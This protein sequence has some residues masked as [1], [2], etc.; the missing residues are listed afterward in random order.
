[1]SITLDIRTDPSLLNLRLINA[2]SALARIAAR[3]GIDETILLQ[4]SGIR[5]DDLKNPAAL[6]TIRQELDVVDRFMAF[7]GIPWMGFEVGKDYNFSSNGKLGIAAMCCDTVLDAMKL[8][9]KYIHLTASYLSYHLVVDEHEARAHLQELIPLGRNRQFFCEAG[10]TSLKCKAEAVLVKTPFREL[11]FAYAEPGYSAKYT[12]HFQC[13]VHFNAERHMIVFNPG[14]LSTPLPMAN[15]LLRQSMEQ[16]CLQL[17]ARMQEQTSLA[18]RVYQEL[19]RAEMDFPS[20]EQVA[21]RINVSSR[22]LRRQLEKENTSFKT[23]LATVRRDKALELLQ[24]TSLSIEA[25]ALRLGFSEVP[26]FYRAFKNWTGHPPGH[27]R[28]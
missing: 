4:G 24:T 2:V 10:V 11:H 20:L 27:F 28:M 16:E 8:V 3:Y 1:M 6:I 21:E 12:E 9:M 15:P 5:P 18:S 25:I 17:L 26:S 13:P 7:V 14:V 19:V 23:M 22:T